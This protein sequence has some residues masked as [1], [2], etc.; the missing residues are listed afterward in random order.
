VALCKRCGEEIA[1]ANELDRAG[2]IDRPRRT[3]FVDRKPRRLTEMHWRLFVLLCSRR[4]ENRPSQG[5]L[6]QGGPGVG[7]IA[8]D[9]KDRCAPGGAPVAPATISAAMATTTLSGA[10]RRTM[11]LPATGGI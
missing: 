8:D 3:V 10:A 2:Y 5:S 9:D 11:A 4:G 6:A 7:R 1:V